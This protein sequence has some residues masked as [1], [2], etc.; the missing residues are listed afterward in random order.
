MQADKCLSNRLLDYINTFIDDLVHNPVYPYPNER[1]TTDEFHNYAIKLYKELRGSVFVS[2]NNQRSIAAGVIYIACV[3]SG[4]NRT[5]KDVAK[6]LGISEMTVRTWWKKVLA[7]LH[8]TSHD[9]FAEHKRRELGYSN[10]I[11]I[12]VSL[13]IKESTDETM[14]LVGHKHFMFSK[15]TIWIDDSIFY[16]FSEDNELALDEAGERWMSVRDFLRFNDRSKYHAG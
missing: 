2:N 5:Q 1:E 16:S 6:S 15:P 7:E 4:M 8:L 9:L 13:H 10:T 12:A 14:D 3:V 11:P